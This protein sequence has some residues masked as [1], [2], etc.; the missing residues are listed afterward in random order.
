MDNDIAS[1]VD[2]WGDM[3]ARLNDGSTVAAINAAWYLSSLKAAE[4]QKGLG[5]WRLRPASLV[6]RVLSTHLITGEAAGMYLTTWMERKN[7][8]TS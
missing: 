8:L 1:V 3:P 2:V 5:E 6:W 7:L 4:D